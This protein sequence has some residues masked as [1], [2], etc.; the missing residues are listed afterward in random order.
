MLLFSTALRSASKQFHD[1]IL[2]DCDLL[3]PVFDVRK[4]HSPTGSLNR[5]FIVLSVC[6]QNFPPGGT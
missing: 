4:T 5:D 3:R 1:V 2:I 6:S